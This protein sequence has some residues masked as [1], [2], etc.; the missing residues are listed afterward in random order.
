MKDIAQEIVAKIKEDHI[1]PASR[2]SMH[3]KSYAFWML[4]GCMIIIGALSLSLVIF[5]VSDIDLRFFRSIELRKLIR[6]VFV[7]A[8]YLWIGLSALALMCGVAAFRKTARGYRQSTLFVTSLV[9]LVVSVLGIASHVLRMDHRMGGL[10][11]RHAPPPLSDFA[12]PMEGRWQRPGDGL[13]GGEVVSLGE[14]QFTLRSFDDQEW[15]VLYDQKDVEVVSVGAKVG[16]IGTKVG[17]FTL[18]AF[19]IRL[20]PMDWDGDF[21]RH[22]ALPSDEPTLR[23]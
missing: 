1:V 8:P 15:R 6:I 19:S 4:M 10:I 21:R 18:R 16:V 12:N 5:N 22:R 13:I 20:F 11:S 3:W 2:W 17:E 7:T 23:R 9:V 14:Q